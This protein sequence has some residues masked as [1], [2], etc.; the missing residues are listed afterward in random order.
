M[1]SYIRDMYR[2]IRYTHLSSERHTS[3]SD[4][5]SAVYALRAARTYHRFGDLASAGRVS[6]V[7]VPDDIEPELGPEYDRP[8]KG[9]HPERALA[10]RNRIDRL[11]QDGVWCYEG[12]YL[13]PT[14]GQWE[15]GGVL[16]GVV[17]FDDDAK[18]QVMEETLAA[19]DDAVELYRREQAE[20]LESRATFAGGGE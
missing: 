6:F 14:T 16:G 2:W 12:R 8:P 11:N 3:E 13:D 17:G 15:I 7:A 9:S 4:M 20:I 18:Y 5:R 19:Y 1:N 10:W